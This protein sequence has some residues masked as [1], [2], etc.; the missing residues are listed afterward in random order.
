MI[1]ETLTHEVHSTASKPNSRANPP[2]SAM[3]DTDP[4][5]TRLAQSNDL[6]GLKKTYSGNLPEIP[7][8]NT[9]EK[10]DGLSGMDWAPPHRTQRIET[11]ATILA[12]EG[13]LKSEI[14]DFGVG[15]G[16]IIPEILKKNPSVQYFG[17]DFSSQCIE[18]GKQKYPQLRFQTARIEEIPD[19]SADTL[20]AMEVLEH[21]EARQVFSVLAQFKRV[22]RKSGTLLITV[23]VHENLKMVTFPCGDCGKIQNLIGHVRSYTPDLIL[24]EL[25]LAGFTPYRTHLLFDF[26]GWRGWVRKNL[27]TALSYLG[28][29]TRPLPCGIVVLANR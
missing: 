2:S 5:R 14:L 26:Y 19:S 1:P 23:P 11:V 13:L 20:M 8:M 6:D 7:A 3:F 18:L 25:K 9:P 21:I 15:W 17:I 22:L 16:D 12:N 29:A 24:A 28:L 27:K 4:L 10:W